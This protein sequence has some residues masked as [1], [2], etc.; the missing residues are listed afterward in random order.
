MTHMPYK[1]RKRRLA[2][3]DLGFED[4]FGE[5]LEISPLSGIRES[6]TAGGVFARGRLRASDFARIGFTLRLVFVR[7]PRRALASLGLF[8][9]MVGFVGGS[10]A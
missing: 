9:I 6:R 1:Q 2:R 4:P 3:Q 10:C 7:L 8:Q 5:Q